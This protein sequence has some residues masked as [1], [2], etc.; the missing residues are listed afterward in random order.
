MIPDIWFLADEII[1]GWQHYHITKILLTSHN[2][3]LPRLGPS[4]AAALKA[5]DEEIKDHG[6]TLPG[7]ISGETFANYAQQFQ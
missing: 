7:M 2:P 3:K 4:R 6:K 1:V 5:M